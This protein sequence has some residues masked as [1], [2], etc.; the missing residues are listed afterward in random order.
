MAYIEHE[1]HGYIYLH[2]VLHATSDNVR[3]SLIVVSFK[4]PK[5]F[6]QGE[7]TSCID[8]CSMLSSQDKTG[9]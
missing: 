3:L 6:K 5:V 1:G 9:H 4:R 7:P 8:K 2:T